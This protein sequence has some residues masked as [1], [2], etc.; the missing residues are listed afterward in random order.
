MIRGPV[1]TMARLARLSSAYNTHHAP[2]TSWQ[3]YGIALY[4]YEEIAMRD[5]I[6]AAALA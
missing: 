4:E 6:A 3:S 5:R 1:F 2:T